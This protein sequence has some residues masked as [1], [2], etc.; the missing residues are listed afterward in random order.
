[1]GRGRTGT[2]PGTARGLVGVIVPSP[3]SVFVS[4]IDDATGQVLGCTAVV[5]VPVVTTVPARPASSPEVKFSCRR[6]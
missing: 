2:V 4:K 1:M 3:G 6:T 5:E